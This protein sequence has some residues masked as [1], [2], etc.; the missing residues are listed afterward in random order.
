MVG[1]PLGDGARVHYRR[2]SR[3]LMP[4][5]RHR[6][7]PVPGLRAKLAGLRQPPSQSGLEVPKILLDEE[8]VALPRGVVREAGDAFVGV[9]R[10]DAGGDRRSLPLDRELVRQPVAERVVDLLRLS[11]EV[12]LHVF[13]D[14]QRKAGEVL[15]P[16]PRDLATSRPMNSDQQTIPSAAR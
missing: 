3:S 15:E 14:E 12:V 13:R 4:R 6:D 11:T 16:L 8:D 9:E 2:G 10:V 1:D 5:L 7:L